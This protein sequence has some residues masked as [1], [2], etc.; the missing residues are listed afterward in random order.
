MINP[1]P[2]LGREVST[3]KQKETFIVFLGRGLPEVYLQWVKKALHHHQIT[4]RFLEVG[5]TPARLVQRARIAT[6]DAKA[7]GSEFDHVWCMFEGVGPLELSHLGARS[8][9]EVAGSMPGIEL[10]LLLHF[11]LVPA[12]ATQE[13]IRDALVPYLPRPDRDIAD[14]ALEGRYAAAVDRARQI[15]VDANISCDIFR[16]VEEVRSS[17]SAFDPTARALI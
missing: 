3:R 5:D 15:A 8:S 1:P 9:V 7:K 16:L 13:E 6:R 4:E 17:L 14:G 12:T 10:W 11:E 2:D